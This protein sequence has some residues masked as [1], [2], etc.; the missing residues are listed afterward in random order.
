MVLIDNFKWYY[1][2]LARMSRLDEEPTRGR[3]RDRV[4]FSFPALVTSS[5]ITATGIDET[6]CEISPGNSIKAS[7]VSECKTRKK[8]QAGLLQTEM[9]H[10][11]LKSTRN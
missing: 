7:T 3:R 10:G 8:L 9:F 6:L 11:V 5:K 2:Y 1:Y 4:K